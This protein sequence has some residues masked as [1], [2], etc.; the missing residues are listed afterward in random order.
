MLPSPPASETAAARSALESHIIPPLMMGCLI[1][2]SSVILVL[3]ILLRSLSSTMCFLPYSFSTAPINTAESEAALF[4]V[5]LRL[6]DPSDWWLLPCFNTR[7]RKLVQ[8]RNFLNSRVQEL[9][10]DLLTGGL[11]LRVEFFKLSAVLL[12]HCPSSYLHRWG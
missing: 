6:T 10:I 8:I 11:T 4:A 12:K 7:Y 2:N 5:P 1:D 3:N 9:L